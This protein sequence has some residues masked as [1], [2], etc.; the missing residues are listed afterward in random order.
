MRVYIPF[1]DGSSVS[2][3]GAGFTLHQRPLDA[4]ALEAPAESKAQAAWSRDWEALVRALEAAW[5]R[6]REEEK[7]ESTRRVYSPKRENS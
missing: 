6:R 5:T 7:R 3:D 1:D 4:D 2:F